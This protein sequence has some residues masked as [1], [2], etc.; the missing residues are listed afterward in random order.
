MKSLLDCGESPSD[1]PVLGRLLRRG[2]GG[3]PSIDL[4]TVAEQARVSGSFHDRGARRTGTRSFFIF[5]RK[6]EVG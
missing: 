4:L 3:S 2:G 6:C 1:L 5:N